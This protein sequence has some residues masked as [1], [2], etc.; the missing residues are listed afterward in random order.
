MIEMCPRDEEREE[1]A[2]RRRKELAKGLDHIRIIPEPH[3]PGT[4]NRQA[5]VMLDSLGGAFS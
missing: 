4:L 1:T 3:L 5:I 2:T